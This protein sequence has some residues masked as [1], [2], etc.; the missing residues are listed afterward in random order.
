MT[1]WVNEILT[2]Q[3]T[4]LAM[5]EQEKFKSPYPPLLKEELILFRL[6]STYKELK[7]RL[8]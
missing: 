7:L 6:K 3:R 1:E 2:S 5:I 4:L 8:L